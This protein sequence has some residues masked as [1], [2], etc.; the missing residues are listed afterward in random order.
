MS[1]SPPFGPHIFRSE[2][3]A[4]EDSV[5]AEQAA[6]AAAA[7]AYLATDKRL[8]MA[9]DLLAA[10]QLAHGT[11]MA[12][13]EHVQQGTAA[14][15]SE[16]A[17]RCLAA[18]FDDPYTFGIVFDAHANRTA[19]RCVFYRDGHEI[20]PIEESG[21]GAVD[22]ASFGLRCAALA[23]CRPAPRGVLVM[24]EPFRFVSVNYRPR[25]VQ[26]LQVLCEELGVQII[27]VTHI[28]ELR[29][30]EVVEL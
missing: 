17:T 30:G 5:A 12:L 27:M 18:V 4:I 8:A 22:V 19:A 28:P 7:D 10:C 9:E 29:I 25:L 20:D 1:S 21:L 15:L 14:R 26:L 23:M 16:I 3:L 11:M 13:A 6:Y 24:D 2:L